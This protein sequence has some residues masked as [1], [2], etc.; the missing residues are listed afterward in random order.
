MLS[1]ISGRSMGGSYLFYHT[2]AETKQVLNV[3]STDTRF[4]LYFL[5][6]KEKPESTFQR[7]SGTVKSLI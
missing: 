4:S 2:G 5:S 6:R 7:F 3:L 1:G